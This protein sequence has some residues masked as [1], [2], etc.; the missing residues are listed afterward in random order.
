MKIQVEPERDS[1]VI[2]AA[3]RAQDSSHC[4]LLLTSQWAGNQDAQGPEDKNVC[5]G[6]THMRFL[7]SPN[8]WGQKVEGGSQALDGGLVVNEDRVQFLQMKSPGG[9]GGD[10]ST[11]V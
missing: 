10:G 4:G 11:T 1:R 6:S 7:D 3:I 5:L 2:S 9:D 8:P